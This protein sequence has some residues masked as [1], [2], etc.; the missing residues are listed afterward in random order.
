MSGGPQ[1]CDFHPQEIPSP[2]F[3]VVVSGI[4]THS[5][6]YAR[7]LGLGFVTPLFFITNIPQSNQFP[8]LNNFTPQMHLYPMCFS[9]SPLPPLS[10]ELPLFGLDGWGSGVKSD[11]II[12]LFKIT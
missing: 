12:S 11:L 3:T 6:A 10:S 5:V 8:G 2:V 4:A 1:T 9:L 7:N